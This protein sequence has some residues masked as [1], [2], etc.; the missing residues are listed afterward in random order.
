M[1]SFYSLLKK[2][3][4]ERKFHKLL[5][6]QIF[7]YYLGLFKITKA[8]IT[9]GIHPQSVN[10]KMIIN[11]PHPLSITDNG[12]NKIANKTLNKLIAYY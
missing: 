12:G 3:K 6:Y 5:S 2:Q 4:T 10:K 9:P 7:I 8:P 11:E 1:W